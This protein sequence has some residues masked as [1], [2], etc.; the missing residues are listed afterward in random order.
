MNTTII[1]IAMICLLASGN[2]MA[3][4]ASQYNMSLQDKVHS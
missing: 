1:T 2:V 3:Q 4:S